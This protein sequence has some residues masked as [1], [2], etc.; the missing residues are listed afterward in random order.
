MND[1]T[2]IVCRCGAE[3]V[4][5]EAEAIFGI[6]AVHKSINHAT[7]TGPGYTVTHRP[8]GMAVWHV[9]EFGDAVAVAKYLDKEQLLPETKDELEQW[10]QTLAPTA[11]GMLMGM[12][13]AIA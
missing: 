10:H 12:L 5:I 6:Y 4:S 11:R 7:A 1:W 8:S 13:T 9:R 3:L 2:T